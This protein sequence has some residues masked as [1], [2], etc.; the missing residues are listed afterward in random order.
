MHGTSQRT[1]YLPRLKGYKRTLLDRIL[2]RPGKPIYEYG[3][4]SGLVE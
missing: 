4:V 3:Y 2:R 1:G